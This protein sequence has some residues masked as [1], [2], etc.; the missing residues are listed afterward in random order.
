[1]ESLRQNKALLYSILASGGV[2]LALTLGVVPELSA[3]IEII[4]FPTD[5]SYYCIPVL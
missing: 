2:V 3:Q 4:D 1:M 5:V